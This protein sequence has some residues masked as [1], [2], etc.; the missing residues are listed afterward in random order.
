MEIDIITRQDLEAFRIRLLKDLKEFIESSPVEEEKE[1]LKSSEV[2]K[3]LKISPGTLQNL[4]ISGK[5]HY[6][7]I[8][9]TYYY[10]YSEIENLLEGAL[11][12]EGNGGW[13][14]RSLTGT[15]Q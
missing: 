15:Y 12:G 8:G 6:S 9:G 3:K 2:R 5:L 13:K 11:K 14:Q 1:W 10:R 7:K 4:R